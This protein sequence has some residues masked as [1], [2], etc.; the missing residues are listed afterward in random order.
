M[1]TQISHNLNPDLR[2]SPNRCFANLSSNTM[3]L[4]EFRGIKFQPRRLF[5]YDFVWF[6][7]LQIYTTAALLVLSIHKKPRFVLNLKTV[8]KILSQYAAATKRIFVFEEIIKWWDPTG[9]PFLST[10]LAQTLEPAA[11]GIPPYNHTTMPTQKTALPYF[12]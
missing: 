6:K 9:A 12:L 10:Q 11:F 5:W 3:P 1:T 7:I 2:E 8:E 4:C